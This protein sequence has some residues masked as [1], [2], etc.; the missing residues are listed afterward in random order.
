MQLFILTPFNPKW[1]TAEFKKLDSI[2]VRAVSETKA[3]DLVNLVTFN[4]E[5]SK[6]GKQIHN[7]WKNRS[8]SKCEIYQGTEFTKDG[9]P[10]ILAPIELNEYFKKLKK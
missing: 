9:K 7:P 8:F 6:I 1:P 3:R 5:K 2:I 10:E 4:S